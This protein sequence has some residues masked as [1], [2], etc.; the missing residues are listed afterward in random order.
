[1]N[2]Y[3]NNFQNQNKILN[4][5][6]LYLQMKLQINKYNHKKKILIIINQKYICNMFKIKYKF[7]RL[8]KY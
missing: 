4:N 2:K 7:L 1:M 6:K 3:Y 5:I 8:Y